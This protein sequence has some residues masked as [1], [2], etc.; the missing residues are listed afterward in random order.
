VT[1]LLEIRD[2]RVQIDLADGR[3]IHP[4]RGVDLSLEA[5]ER[6]GLIGESGCG[7][8]TTMLA[9]LGLLPPNATVSGEIRLRG[10]NVLAEGERGVRRYRATDLALIPQSAMNALN[11]VKSVGAQLVEILRYHQ[12]SD[13]RSAQRRAAELLETVD[14]PVAK[15]RSYPHELSGGMRQRV[16]IAMALS[17]DPA[18]ILADEPTTALDVIVQAQILEVLRRLSEDRGLALVLVTHDIPIVSSLCTRAGVMYAGRVVETA[19]VE[20][21]Y[22][23]PAHPYTAALLGA[24]PDLH[25]D[26][27]GGAIAG[28][29]PALSEAISGCPFEPRC[30]SSLPVCRALDPPAADAGTDQIVRCHNPLHLAPTVARRGA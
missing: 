7:K 14:V 23:G 3:R 25:R 21:L 13:R 6:L 10:T 22:H 30:S 8:S 9:V 18:I 27:G 4:V 1:P 15:L 24:V 20:D 12:G 29:P 28:R 11:P 26:S 19:G 2:L 5:G 17:C 16:C